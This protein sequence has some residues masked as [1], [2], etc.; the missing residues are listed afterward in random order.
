MLLAALELGFQFV[1]GVEMVLDGTFVATCHKYHVADPGGICFLDRVLDE[2]LIDHRQHFLGLGL[3]R[4][5]KAGA[6]GPQ[7]ETPLC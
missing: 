5:K 7:P 2:R 4:R 3:G 6:Q 1:G